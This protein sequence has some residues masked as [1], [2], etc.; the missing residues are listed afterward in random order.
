MRFSLSDASLRDAVVRRKK[1]DF[2]AKE[3]V[4]WREGGREKGKEE[5]SD[6][7]LGSLEGEVKA[8]RE[9]KEAVFQE[10]ERMRVRRRDGEREAD[11]RRPLR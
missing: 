4:I 1:K 8:L 9:E 7:I 5:R 2:E 10:L 3:K 6:T 11:V